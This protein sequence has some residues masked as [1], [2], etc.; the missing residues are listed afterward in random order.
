MSELFKLYPQDPTS[1]SK[2]IVLKGRDDREPITLNILGWR[3][4]LPNK[5]AVHVQSAEVG[6]YQCTALDSNCI[7]EVTI[8]VHND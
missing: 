1:D 6:A 4:I 2:L 8:S 5:I 3:R 7:I